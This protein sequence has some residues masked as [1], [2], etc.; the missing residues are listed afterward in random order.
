MTL[1]D[2]WYKLGELMKPKPLGLSLMSTDFDD[3]FRSSGGNKSDK[4]VSRSI[5][6]VSMATHVANTSPS[7]ANS[8]KLSTNWQAYLT[9]AASAHRFKSLS[10]LQI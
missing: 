3:Q 1:H 10:L 7:F 8:T 9:K 2:I 6:V 5:N 4:N